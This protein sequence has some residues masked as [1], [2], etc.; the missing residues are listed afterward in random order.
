MN[1]NRHCHVQIQTN[2]TLLDYEWIEIFEKYVPKLS[3]SISLDPKGKLDLRGSDKMEYRQVV[4]DNIKKFINR[5]E[6]IELYQLHM[7]IMWMILFHLYWNCRNLEF[8]V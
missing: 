4:V 3:L 7:L 6:N 8:L 2:G 1:F 5:I